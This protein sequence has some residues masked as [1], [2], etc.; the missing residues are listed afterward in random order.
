MRSAALDAARGLRAAGARSALVTAGRHGVAGAADD[1]C[2]WV[3]APSVDGS[4]SR[5]R[6]RFVRG[7]SRDRPRARRLAA[8]GDH[9]RGRHR[10]RV[11]GPS[12]R[13]RRR[14]RCWS[15]S[16]SP[17]SRWSPH[18]QAQPSDARRRGRAG[19]RE[20]EDGLARAQRRVR[21]GARDAREGPRGRALAGL[22]PEPARPLARLRAVERRHR[23]D[24]LRRRGSLL[25]R[26]DRERRAGPSRPRPA[27][28]DRE[29]PRR[30]GP[31][32]EDR[33]RARRAPR[34][35]AAPH[36]RARRC[37]VPRGRHRAR[38]RRRSRWIVRSKASRSTPSSSRIAS[39][40]PTPCAS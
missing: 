6:G 29:P 17:R 5:R 18:E 38:A 34:R 28:R 21:R 24:H 3:A 32:A 9:R 30:C 27:A 15:P 40:R 7:R 33:A 19:R 8:G 22:P 13:R 31:A 1:G 11:R 4:Q 10:Q 35:R 26:A 36:S 39:A 14:S 20:P 37:V 25:R 23:P 2:F 12:A 16:C